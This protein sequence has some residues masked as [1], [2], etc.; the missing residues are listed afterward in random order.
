MSQLHSLAMSQGLC[1]KTRLWSE[2]GRQEL[3]GLTLDRWPVGAGRSCFTREK[4]GGG[5][6]HP[7]R[8]RVREAAFLGPSPRHFRIRFPHQA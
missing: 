2:Y 5:R 3:E 1:R 4:P 6:C 8:M 7:K